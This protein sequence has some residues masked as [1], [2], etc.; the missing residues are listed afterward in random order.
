MD[1]NIFTDVRK[2][3]I[4]DYMVEHDVKSRADLIKNIKE[5]DEYLADPEKLKAECNGAFP[6]ITF[7]D[8]IVNTT[9][10]ELVTELK[11]IRELFKLGVDMDIDY[12]LVNRRIEEEPEFS[13]PLNKIGN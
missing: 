6:G 8:E 1:K 11:K 2:Q 3:L 12:E 10:D 13:V 7:P 9:M 5:I 4:E